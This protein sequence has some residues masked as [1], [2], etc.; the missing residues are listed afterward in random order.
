MCMCAGICV[1]PVCHRLKK[2]KTCEKN[3][4][5]KSMVTFQSFHVCEIN[6]ERKLKKNTYTQMRE[7]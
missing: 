1:F 2:S 6:L 7:K 4:F 5:L 3:N